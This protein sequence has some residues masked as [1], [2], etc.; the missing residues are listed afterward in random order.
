VEELRV[1]I[2]SSSG[3]GEVSFSLCSAP[4]VNRIEVLGTKGKVTADWQT[5]TVLT[6]RESEL[7]SVLA[8]F[9]ENIATALDLIRSGTGTLLAIA[10]GKVRRSQGRRT[11]IEQFYQSLRDGSPTPVSPEQGVLNVRL[12]D[13]IKEACKPFRKQRPGLSISRSPSIPVQEW[14]LTW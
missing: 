11:I 14:G 4:G 13:Q 3:L 8:R 9:T 6:Y 1:L 7:P 10:T 5:M 12:I 2:P